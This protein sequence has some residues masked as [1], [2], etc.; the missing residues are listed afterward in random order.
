MNSSDEPQIGPVTKKSQ[1]QHL[2]EF[3]EAIWSDQVLTKDSV[4]EHVGSLDNRPHFG[5]ALVE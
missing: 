1:L 2:G 4:R 5:A 3:V